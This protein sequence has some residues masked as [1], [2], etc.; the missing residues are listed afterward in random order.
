MLSYTT[1]KLGKGWV[2]ALNNALDETGAA[3]GPL[4][5]AGVLFRNH[6][7]ET[8]YAL[9]LMPTLLALAALT[10]ARVVFTRPERLDEGRTAPTKGLTRAYWF[11]MLGAACFAAGLM[12]FELVAYHLSS[13]GTVLGH[14]LPIFLALST[15]AGIVASLIL[16]KLY[17]RVGLPILLVAVLISAAFAP[18]VFFGGFAMALG[19]LLLW[20]VG[21]ATQ[22]TLFKAVI[23]G[24]L[25]EGKR[26]T[27][28][29]LF[30]AG[31]GVGWL[32]GSLAA[33]MLYDRS[34]LGL[35]TFSIAAQ[36]ASLPLFLVASR[37]GKAA[38]A[39]AS[40]GQR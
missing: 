21:Y 19:G 33:G 14:W 1:G 9:L 17:D 39:E 8:G 24:V 3:L 23:A 25:P 15:G 29:G 31:Y 22:D 30:Y 18:L 13:T 32:A 12:S 36:L 7:Y 26:N 27:A 6:G 34:R 4:A 11:Y 28:F 40:V 35:V 37:S 38:K 5:M 2:Y 20:G 16:G 10:T